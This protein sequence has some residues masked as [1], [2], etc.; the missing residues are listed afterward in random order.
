LP[1]S[2]RV[3]RNSAAGFQPHVVYLG[4]S[5]VVRQKPRLYALSQCKTALSPGPQF[6]DRVK[7]WNPIHPLYAIS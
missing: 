3:L 2:A 4:H 6:V 1:E 7:S 5:N